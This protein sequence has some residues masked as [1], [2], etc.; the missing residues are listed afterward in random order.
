MGPMPP[1]ASVNVE[2]VQPSFN[3]VADL[4]AAEAVLCY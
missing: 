4:A 1:I 3:K 2:N